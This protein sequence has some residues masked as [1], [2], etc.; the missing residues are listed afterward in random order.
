MVYKLKT[1]KMP[2][3]VLVSIYDENKIELEN[4]FSKENMCGVCLSKS[5][6][7]RDEGETFVCFGST[8]MNFSSD[9][10]CCAL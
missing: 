1:T 5:R 6:G 3:Y 8:L 10:D 7:V 4:T 9:T 2:V